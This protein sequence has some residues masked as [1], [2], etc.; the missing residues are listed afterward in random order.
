MRGW[1][2]VNNQDWR[3]G[4]TRVTP[5]DYRLIEVIPLPLFYSHVSPPATLLDHPYSTLGWRLVVCGAA[6][7]SFLRK[8]GTWAR[9]REGG[10]GTLKAR[11]ACSREGI[12]SIVE[13]RGIMGFFTDVVFLC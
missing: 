1:G 9:G 11:V 8:S 5:T 13:H 12:V 4:P 7:N 2:K 10:S 3:V 6:T